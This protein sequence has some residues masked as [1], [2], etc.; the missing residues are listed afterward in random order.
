MTRLGAN[1][2]TDVTGFGLLG[3]AF[4]MAKGSGVTLE[5]ESGAVPLLPEVL[6]LIEQGMLTRG[7]KN[8]RIY[9][10]DSV[11]FDGKVSSTMQSAMFDPQTAGG[12]LISIPQE[13]VDEF[14]TEIPAAAVIGEVKENSGPLINVR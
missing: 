4:E 3:H 7:D 2:C 13:V 5:I 14:L 8:N 12:L 10:G 6:E 1:A 11:R 9:V